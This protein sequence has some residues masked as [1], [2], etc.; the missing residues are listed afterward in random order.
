MFLYFLVITSTKLHI[1]R[2]NADQFS[3]AHLKDCTLKAETFK[4]DA[5]NTIFH[6]DDNNK[7]QYHHQPHM[8]NGDN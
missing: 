3:N 1:G 2:S 5:H 4:S 7:P 6:V 8:A